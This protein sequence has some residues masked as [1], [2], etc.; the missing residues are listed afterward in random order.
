MYVLRIGLFFLVLAQCLPAWADWEVSGQGKLLLS[1]S[2]YLSDDF[3]SVATGEQQYSDLNANARLMA[4][5]RWDS[6]DF[7][8][9][10]QLSG[11][12]GDSL[13]IP[14]SASPFSTSTIINDDSR[15]L[16]LSMELENSSSGRWSQRLDRLNLGYAGRQL[17]WRVGRQA[18][19]WGN[20]LAYNP[21]DIF[22][23]FSPLAIDTEYKTG[24]D[25]FYAQWLFQNGD[26]LQ[27]I[28][29]PRRDPADG[30]VKP[31]LASTAIK[32]RTMSGVTDWD[33]LLARHYGENLLAIG[34]VRDVGGAIWRLDANVTQLEDGRT[35][36]FAMSNMDYSWIAFGHNVY[37]FIEYYHNSLG[38]ESVS[39]A[40]L[41]SALVSR[42]QRG[43][44][45]SLGRDEVALGLMVELTP[46]WQSNVTLLR[47]LHDRSS[48]LSLT[49]NYDWLQDTK[50][51]F[52]AQISLGERDTEFGGI[53]Y[54]D[55]V[56]SL[57]G[58]IGAPSRLYL[59]IQ[60]YY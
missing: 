43:E 17:V 44:V 10:Y 49:G 23:P 7:N 57:S 2:A 33:L 12:S 35:A 34:H 36:L 37:G 55:P 11:A 41:D 16:D 52:G 42:L 3:V 5:N 26:D 59:Y 56:S 50:L 29:L 18:I 13:N 14:L 39:L 1:H 40:G 19:S 38:A 28:F 32:F 25:L 9:H 60:Q 51:M 27:L 54:T 24:D 15:L 22:N 58:Y 21:M 46:R 20:G 45:H 6:Y 47:N 8:L 53:A 4:S 31:A 48:L 30:A